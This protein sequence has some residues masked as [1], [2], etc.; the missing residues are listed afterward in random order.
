MEQ[1]RETKFKIKF[2]IIMSFLGWLPAYC[3][4]RL[5]MVSRTIINNFYYNFCTMA[6][7]NTELG[8]I[9]GLCLGETSLFFIFFLE[10]ISS[11]FCSKLFLFLQD[12]E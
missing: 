4:G 1:I 6:L 8:L 2:Q 11:Y 3:D 5:Q 10:M 9:L 12:V 7:T